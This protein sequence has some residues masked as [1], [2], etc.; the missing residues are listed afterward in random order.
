M[1]QSVLPKGRHRRRLAP[2]PAATQIRPA[3]LSS[4]VEPPEGK[5]EERN[6]IALKMLGSNVA[7]DLVSQFTGLTVKQI[8]KLQKLSAKRSQK[9]KKSTK[10]NQSS[11]S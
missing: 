5:A 7:V 9:P 8:E 6:Q 11:K 1:F 3:G 4:H 10:P 2:R